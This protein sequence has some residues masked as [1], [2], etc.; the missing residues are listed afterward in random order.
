MQKATKAILLGAAVA[1]TACADF[2]EKYEN[3]IVGRKIRPFAIVTDPPEAAPGD[4]VKVELK[5]YHA[6]KAYA[7]DWE[8]GL[9]YQVNQG[10]TSS[11]F[12][13]ASEIIDLETGELK[14]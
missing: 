5:M 4:T 10:A 6:D 2:P 12:P 13:T 3:V 7:V 1:L 14:L 8:L 11:G 9:K